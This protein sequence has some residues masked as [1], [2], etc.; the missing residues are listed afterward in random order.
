MN[1]QKYELRISRLTIDKLGIQMYDRVSAVLAELIANA[2]DADAEKVT[3]TLP[4]GKMVGN[5]EADHQMDEAI[6]IVDDGHGM[7]PQEVNEYYLNI[8]YD[9]RRKRGDKTPKG[10][11]VMGRKGIGKLAPFG[12][13]REVEVESAGGE[14]T[15]GGYRIAHLILDFD[16]MR[17]DDVDDAG[18]RVPYFPTA[19][20]RDGSLAPTSGT[21]ITMRRFNRKRVP[22]LEVMNRQLSARFGIRRDDWRVRV[23]NSLDEDASFELGQLPVDTMDGSKVDVDDRP[24][25]IN[26]V[27]HPVSGWVAYSKQPYKDEV[28]AGVRIYCRGKFVAQTRDFDINTGFTGEF[29]MRSYLTGEIHAEWLDDGNNDLIR[30]DRQGIIW[31]S[32]EGAAF[33]AWGRQLLKAVAQKSERG[34]RRQT[35]DEFLAQSQLQQRIEK[36]LPG[37]NEIHRAILDAAKMIVRGLSGDALRDTEYVESIVRL[38]YSVGPHRELLESLRRASQSKSGDIDAFLKFFE[39][40]QIA[41]RFSLGQIAHER[42]QTIERLESLVTDRSTVERDL[43]KMIEEASW[44][45][46]PEWTPLS[47]NRTLD[48]TRKAFESWWYDRHNERIVTTTIQAK[49]KRPDFVLIAHHRELLIVEIKR[50]GYALKDNEL[51]R[52]HGYLVAL[53]EFLENNP[54]FGDEFAEN[55]VKL[56]IVCD[57]LGLSPGHARIMVSETFIEKRSWSEVLLATKQVHAEYLDATDM[58]GVAGLEPKHD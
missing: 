1:E 37:K 5:A 3:V 11:R 29:K 20:E 13:C 18:K 55:R 45:L 4:L 28:M 10:R 56:I 47:K 41:E 14:R 15:N 40:A 42:V 34:A 46:F 36:S 51:M 49:D 21:T 8:G 26:G 52:A 43:Q 48:N 27:N 16:E 22:N 23:I 12:I 30:T 9:R 44:L 35:W 57:E 17:E 54:K 2:Y 24:L 50:P 25:I 19:G 58:P 7:D 53:T 31:T 39:T 38:A 32:E 6:S 33:R